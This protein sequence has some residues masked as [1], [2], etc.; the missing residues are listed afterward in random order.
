MS[1]RLLFEAIKYGEAVADL[2]VRV[3]WGQI[4]A[5]DERLASELGKKLAEKV[6]NLR[7]E[8]KRHSR[9]SDA[10][11]TSAAQSL[12]DI[13]SERR[14][15]PEF[16]DKMVTMMESAFSARREAA[17]VGRRKVETF[18]KLQ[19]VVTLRKPTPR[20]AP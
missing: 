4:E 19:P 8:T 12:R 6:A 13:L 10:V 15:E 1:D 9:N 2:C 14:A 18:R 7:L 3:N 11:H 17:R 16:I 20:S 5:F